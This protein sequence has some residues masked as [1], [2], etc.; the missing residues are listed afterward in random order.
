MPVAVVA[1]A[2]LVTADAQGVVYGIAMHYGACQAALVVQDGNDMPAV[3]E[4]ILAAAI[5]TF[6]QPSAKG[7]VGEG[8]LTGLAVVC[9]WGGK[10]LFLTQ[11]NRKTKK[12]FT[13]NLILALTGTVSLNYIPKRV[14]I[15]V[16]NKDLT[17]PSLSVEIIGGYSGHGLGQAAAKGACQTFLDDALSNGKFVKGAN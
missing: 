11:P 5:Y 4:I 17:P 12:I 10:S 13:I 7:A 6:T 8:G 2:F 16:K 9:R 3:I 15:F 14:K 1:V